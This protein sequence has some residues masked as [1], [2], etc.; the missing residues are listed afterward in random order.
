MFTIYFFPARRQPAL[1]AN[2]EFGH[3]NDTF[4]VKLTP[5][6]HSVVKYTLKLN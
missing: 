2:T 1:T 4:V 3:C 6:P 5:K